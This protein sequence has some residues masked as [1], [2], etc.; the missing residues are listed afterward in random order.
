[1]TRVVRL[2]LGHSLS[3]A[4]RLD[5]AFARAQELDDGTSPEV[6]AIVE[7][8]L[9][10]DASA[11]MRL[12]RA[13]LFLHDQATAAVTRE[14]HAALRRWMQANRELV[15]R[16]RGSVR[17]KPLNPGERRWSEATTTKGV[18]DR[19]RTVVVDGREVVF[20]VGTPV[21]RG[22]VRWSRTQGTLPP[23]ESDAS[24]G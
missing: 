11:L 1:M 5:A 3:T 7:F 18:S 4:E 21:S 8:P 13:D 12:D 2:D 16:W 15:M 9:R 19:P 22:T 23:A 24:P 10:G 14:E 17:P 20:P 6:E